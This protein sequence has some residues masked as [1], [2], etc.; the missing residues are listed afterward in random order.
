MP[1][2]MATP[3]WIGAGIRNLSPCISRHHKI[4]VSRSETTSCSDTNSVHADSTLTTWIIYEMFFRQNWYR[5]Y[6]NTFLHIYIYARKIGSRQN[7]L[8]FPW[9]EKR[10][11]IFHDFQKLYEPC[12]LKSLYQFKNTGISGFEEFFFFFFFMKNTKSVLR[13]TQ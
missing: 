8:T 3:I 1:A 10:L 9:L 4:P 6:Y 7:F 2:F 13:K 12:N 11:P 5:Y